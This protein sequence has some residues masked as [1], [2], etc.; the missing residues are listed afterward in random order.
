ML[1]DLVAKIDDY[2]DGNSSLRQFKE[3]FFDLSFDVERN[4]S[5][6]FVKLVNRIE[7]ILAESSAGCW[8]SAVL[9]QA[10]D[11][12]ISPYRSNPRVIFVEIDNDSAKTSISSVPWELVAAGHSAI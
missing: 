9:D 1:N 3:W 11:S 5:G 4:F 2:L 10:L 8:S 7:G 6:P 12:V